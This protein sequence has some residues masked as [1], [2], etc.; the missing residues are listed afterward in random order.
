MI[1][2]NRVITLSMVLYAGFLLPIMT[3]RRP[4]GLSGI[5]T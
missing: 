4:M 5:V 1:L 2:S 3:G